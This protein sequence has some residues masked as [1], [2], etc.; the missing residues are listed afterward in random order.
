MGYKRYRAYR[1]AI[2]CSSLFIYR[3]EPTIYT[4][5]MTLVVKGRDSNSLHGSSIIDS[6]Q[7]QSTYVHGQ[8]RHKQRPRARVGM[9]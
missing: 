2:N 1:A 6:R 4:S 8:Y 9:G 5:G 3:L 7:H